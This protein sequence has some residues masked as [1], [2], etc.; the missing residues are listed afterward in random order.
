MDYGLMREL[1][2]VDPQYLSAIRF[3]QRCILLYEETMKAMGFIPQQ[4]QS[5]V[6]DSSRIAYQ[7]PAEI[8][9]NYA[10]F[11]EYY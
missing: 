2:V 5:R 7:I 10:S 1:G 6:V 4:P 8:R 11:P 9:V 3:A